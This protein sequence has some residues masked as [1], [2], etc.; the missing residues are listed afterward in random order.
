MDWVMGMGILNN[1]IQDNKPLNKGGD[2]KE[3]EKNNI[4]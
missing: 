2:L 3:E 4:F 1:F